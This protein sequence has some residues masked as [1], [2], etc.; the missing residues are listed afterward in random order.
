LNKSADERKNKLQF[1]GEVKEKNV[2]RRIE[3]CEWGR[4]EKRQDL[5][6]IKIKLF[7]I[8]VIE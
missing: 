7:K 3:V 8:V 6:K 4:N 5:F 1:G 2:L